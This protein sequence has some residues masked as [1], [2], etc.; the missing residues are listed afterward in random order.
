MTSKTLRGIVD[1]QIALLSGLQVH[2]LRF[3][4]AL[5]NRFETE[6]S[7]RRCSRFW[8]E[9]LIAIALFDLFL[10]ADHLGTTQHF[11][12]SLLVR[13]GFLTPVALAVTFNMRRKPS[14]TVRETSIAVVAC[15]AGI[16]H[17]CLEAGIDAVS[18][19][20]AQFGAL[21]AILFASTLMRLRFPYAAAS[22]VVMVLA[23]V[24]FLRNDRLLDP[25]EKPLCLCLMLGTVAVTLIAN[26]S[27]NREERLNYMLCLRGDVLVDD[28]SRSNDK[29]GRLAESD[30]LTG[31]ANRHAFDRRFEEKWIAAH[32]DGALLSVILVDVDNFKKLNDHYGHLYGDVVLRRIAHLLQEALRKRGDFASRYGGEEFVIVLPGTTLSHAVNV[33]ERVRQL[34]EIA[35]FPPVETSEALTEIKATIS[36]GVATASPLHDTGRE[37][38]F[39][40]ADKAL[41]EA[42]A[43]G[44]NRVLAAPSS[45]YTSSCV[46]ASDP[47]SAGTV[48]EQSG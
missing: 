5:E 31:L 34:V 15:L 23:D 40:L 2:W 1:N 11:R 10:F 22:S 29:L 42:K 28:L 30:A 9:G 43:L 24:L 32:R 4:Q 37:H 46:R 16:A 48:S 12:D 47:V 19:A 21:A 35:G 26:Y 38:L 44:R 33:A 45:A 41:Y 3:P 18:S 25:K 14:E 27:S 6:T 8:L 13:L 17:L 39:E 7:A 20:L 36:C